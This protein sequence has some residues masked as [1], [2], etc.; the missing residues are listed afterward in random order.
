[1][2]TNTAAIKKYSMLDKEPF[3]VNAIPYPA[4]N[5][6]IPRIKEITFNFGFLSL[7]LL[8]DIN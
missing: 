7:A 4:A 6:P 2:I 8:F 1:M 3:I 5:V